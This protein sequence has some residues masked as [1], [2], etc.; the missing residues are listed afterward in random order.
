LVSNRRLVDAAGP[1]FYPTPEWGTR[2]LLRHV[3]FDGPILEPCCGDGAMAEVLKETGQPVTGSDI[4]DRGYG[5][6]Q[7]FLDIREPHA[8]IVTNPPFNVAESLLEHALSLASQKVCFLLRT[9]FLESRRRYSA[10][11]KTTPPT[12]VLVFAERLSMYPKGHDVN[13]GGTTSYAWFVWDKL[14][15]SNVTA[16]EWIAPGMKPPSRRR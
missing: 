13:G 12:K 4:V 6:V 10:F 15:D 2:A 11:Y 9:A 1:D 8:N 14:A 16:I 7:D 5:S 3:Q